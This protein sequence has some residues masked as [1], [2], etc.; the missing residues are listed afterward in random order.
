MSLPIFA[1]EADFK[2]AITQHH[3]VVSAATGSGKSTCLPVWASDFGKVLVVQ[4]RRI[5]CTSLAEYLASERNQ[6]VGE[7][8]GYAIRFEQAFTDETRVVFATPGVALRWY[9]DNKLAN[10]DFIL[11][12]E[13]HERRWDMDLLLA[14]LKN[15]QQ[16]RIIVTSATLQ[17]DV[18]CKYLNAKKLESIGSLFDVSERYFAS[19][20]RAMPSADN[21]SHRVYDAC[22]FALQY[23]DGDVLVFLPGKSEI[24]Q[25]LSVCRMLDAHLIPLF[26][27]C[28]HN[29]QEAALNPSQKRRII[30]ATNVAETSLTIPN[31]TC[32]IDSGLERRNHLRLG[33]TI[34]ALDAISQDAAK[35]RKGRAGR[36]QQGL[37][38]RLYGQYAPLISHTPPEVQRTA[39]NELVLSAG[40]LANGI[41]SLDFLEPLPK[42]SLTRAIA[43]LTNLAV[44]DATTL[45]ATELGRALYPLPLDIELSHI[46]CSM[47]NN[48]L[49]QAAIDLVSL[50][51]VPSQVYTLP[52]RIEDIELLAKRYPNRSDLEII[53]DVVRGK[54][55]EFVTN[56]DALVEAKQHS[57][58]LRQL[59][60][61]PE[62]KYA[63]RY[64][65]LA[66]V[67]AIADADP[68]RLFVKRNN[69]R[70]AFG[71]GD[72]EIVL[73]K[74]S[75]M[76]ES[77]FG[78][79]VLD[80]FTL[81]A[82][83]NK[84][85]STIATVATEA[86]KSL[87]C[88]SRNCSSS[89]DDVQLN[90][91]ELTVT[92]VKRYAGVIVDTYI[93][94]PTIEELPYALTLATQR[95]QIF[96][97]VFQKVDEAIRYHTLQLALDKKQAELPSPFD[98]IQKQ[99]VALGVESLFDIELLEAHDLQYTGIESWQIDALK[100]K[101]P[102]T[103][104]LA[105]QMLN[106][107]YHLSAKRVTVE[108]VKGLRKEAPKRWELP[109][110]AGL[111]IEYKRASKIVAIKN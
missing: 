29:D 74:H 81:A 77:N 48:T 92:V 17:T 38:I 22:E 4:P 108:Y 21:L 78:V 55:N 1:I 70:G 109:A 107:H 86:P 100:E 101:Y 61:L 10:F 41:D 66:L 96:D 14:V 25:T 65:H 89:I 9:F 51:A 90:E 6:T 53:I 102:L 5:A 49:R 20:V 88:N 36:T 33:K 104:T 30:L 32:V 57:E 28:H 44:I 105:G 75:R 11:L 47:P 56:H 27:G 64:D 18:F 31:I 95:Q 98:F 35:Q 99:Y 40:C 67:S 2:H 97:D 16:H 34:L 50:L 59:F 80:S 69:R 87:F 54:L 103:L 52:T 45:V 83:G 82:K 73:A 84:Q 8:I 15:K 62:L 3:V 93:R 106:V 60:D 68:S 76:T 43:T 19:D 39:L 13:F 79:L 71:N 110:W 63:A 7:D 94:E 46:I 24:Q 12:D 23:T 85:A 111:N 26:S 91:Q 72:S 37:C 58:N 42:N